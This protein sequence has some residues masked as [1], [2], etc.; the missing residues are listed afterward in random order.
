MALDNE[1]NGAY[2]L[3]TNQPA[4]RLA[5]RLAF[6]VAGFGLACWAP[7]V[8]IVKQ[9]LNLDEALLGLL[10]LCLGVG[11]ISAMLFTG[12]LSARYGSKPII[13]AGGFGLTFILP[14]LVIVTS[15]LAL[16]VA[17]FGFGASLGAI[18]VAM[19]IH[20]VDVERAADRPLMSGFHAL[21]SVGGFIG[22]G[23]TTFL[24]SL[25]ITPLLS[26]L[27]CAALMLI[28]MLI[29]WP[30]LLPDSG[31]TAINSTDKTPLIVIP[32][33]AV[34][35]LSLLAAIMFLI[36]G[37]ILDWGALLITGMEQVEK[38]Q[39]GL[40]YMLFAI[41]MTFGRFRGDAISARLGDKALIFW[42]GLMTFAGF[43]VLLCIPVPFIALSGF[44]LIGLGASN[45]VPV[46]FRRAGSQ[47][48]M[49]PA[50]AVAAIGTFGY[51]GIL[52]GPAII[53]FVADIFSLPISFWMLAA[54]VCLV[55]LSANKVTHLD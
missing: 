54:L 52:V 29:T 4:T 28:V 43:I 48:S 6:L 38:A 42:G 45:I 47:T 3:D 18:D 12:I 14:L 34:L 36:E 44:F 11:A 26:C 30:K 7:L 23:A 41:A 19:N 2:M 21:F 15:P 13:I 9:Q 24:L 27:V 22:A 25:N 20:A 35:L 31:K 37:A 40:G 39:G 17:L 8:P 5:T 10:L 33:G 50:L 32:K 53:G 16:G 49:P 55:S 51:A 1:L 46:F